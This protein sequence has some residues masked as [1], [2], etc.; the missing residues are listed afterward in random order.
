LLEHGGKPY[1]FIA[2]RS[3]SRIVMLAHRGLRHPS[4]R[5]RLIVGSCV[6]RPDTDGFGEGKTL[7]GFPK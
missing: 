3:R 5:D 7:I 4:H 2:Q 6:S 1:G